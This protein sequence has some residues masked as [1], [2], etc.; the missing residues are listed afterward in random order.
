[1]AHRIGL[2]YSW[3]DTEKRQRMPLVSKRK[4]KPLIYH[5]T[6]DIIYVT[7][8]SPWLGYF[9]FYYILSMKIYNNK[10]QI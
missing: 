10:L 5:G 1:M 3:A 2:A 4:E 9:Y 7:E 6:V 8:I